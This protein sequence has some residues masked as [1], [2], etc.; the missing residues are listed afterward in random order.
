MGWT[1]KKIYVWFFE[2]M[3]SL[4]FFQSY[5]RTSSIRTSTA[6]TISASVF[7][8]N[9]FNTTSTTTAATASKFEFSFVFPSNWITYSVKTLTMF[10]YILFQQQPVM[11][12]D[13]SIIHTQFHQP[14]VLV[15]ANPYLHE[16]KE[17]LLY[18]SVASNYPWLTI[19]F[20]MVSRYLYYWGNK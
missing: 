5:S 3:F 12:A 6:T 18:S 15:P 19:G 11:L 20:N 7:L 2:I 14:H 4:F 9:I 17:Q 8:A 10:V 1:P 16:G 13:S